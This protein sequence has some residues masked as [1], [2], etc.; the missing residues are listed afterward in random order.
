MGEPNCNHLSLYHQRR[1]SKKDVTDA[2][3]CVCTALHDHHW[4]KSPVH[5]IRLKILGGEYDEYKVL[6][7]S[8]LSLVH[9]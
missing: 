8:S 6:M 3:A 2:F 5:S 9:T 1:Q 4:G 7:S